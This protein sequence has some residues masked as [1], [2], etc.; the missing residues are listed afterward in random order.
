MSYLSFFLIQCSMGYDETEIIKYVM[1]GKKEELSQIPVGQPN[2][3]IE[4]ETGKA[5]LRPVYLFWDKTD[6]KM[7]QLYGCCARQGRK[8]IGSLARSALSAVAVRH[9]QNKYKEV[10][11]SNPETLFLSEKAER[12][13]PWG[14]WQ[15]TPGQQERLHLK[16]ARAQAREI[17]R[18]CREQITLF[19]ILSPE[20]SY[21]EVYDMLLMAEKEAGVHLSDLFLLGEMSQKENAEEILEDFYEESGIAGSFYEACEYKKIVAT[22]SGCSFLLDYRGLTVKELGRPTFYIDGAGV[23][24]GKEIH[25]LEGVCGTCRS[26]RK[27]LDRAFL[28]AL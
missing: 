1:F 19:L 12:E 13:I 8:G 16:Y 5:E 17:L 14:F 11:L 24:T 7:V 25:R 15:L 28:S 21:A 10:F 26:L 22:V 9:I 3:V 20:C 6:E 18:N 23:R 2:V 4:D 27:H